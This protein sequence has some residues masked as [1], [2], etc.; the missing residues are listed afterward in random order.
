[1]MLKPNAQTA[2]IKEQFIND[3]VTGLLLIFRV[4]SSGEARLQLQGDIL[5]Y[6]NRDFQFDMNGELAGTGTGLC[7]KDNNTGDNL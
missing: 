5:P 6:G 1:M 7:H 4:T 2:R 3:E